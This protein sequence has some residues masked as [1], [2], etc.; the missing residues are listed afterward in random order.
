MPERTDFGGG[1]NGGHEGL[2]AAQRY[3]ADYD[4][5]I[6]YYPAAQNLALVLSWFRM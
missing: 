2:V 6:A 3:G 4:G 1:S 5:V